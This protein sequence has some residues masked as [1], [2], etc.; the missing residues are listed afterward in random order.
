LLF[1][2]F[3]K[4]FLV[5]A[6]IATMSLVAVGCATTQDETVEIGYV[7]WACATASSYL[8]KNVIETE[9]GM[10]VE[11]KDMEAGIMWQSVSS[12]DVDFIVCAWLPGTHKEYY[13]QLQDDL[14]N[15][16]PN[17]EGALI[18]L[19]VPAYVEINSIEEL[20]DHLDR[21]DGRIVG[22]DAGAGIMAATNTALAEYGLDMELLESSDAA[23]TTELRTA[24]RNNEWIVVTGWAPHWKFAEWDLKFLE[25]PKG[26]F[27]GAETI[28]TIAR[29]GFSTDNPTVQ[30]FLDNYFLT[31]EQLGGLISMME[32]YDDRDEAAQAW[33]EQN[34]EVVDGWLG[35]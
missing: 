22:I 8:A 12:G 1:V 33:I 31:A 35:R 29:K 19:V 14:V 24:I 11:L 15:V 3:S 4:G 34:K 5:V 6:L 30:A 13:E 18:G 17:Y 9:L 16:G 20:A 7:N 25:D 2:R 32:E 21:F 28:N 27:G 23:M 10:E 26:V